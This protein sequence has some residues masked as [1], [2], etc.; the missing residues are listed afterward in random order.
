M[1]ACLS[2]RFPIEFTSTNYITQAK[3]RKQVEGHLRV[4]LKIDGAFQT[5]T[6]TSSSEPL[7]SE[8]AYVVMQRQSFN[9]PNALKSVMEGFSISKGDRGEFLVLLLLVLARDATIGVP[10][11][12]GRPITGRR[13]FG[14]SDFLYGQL[15]RQQT[16]SLRTVDKHSIQALNMLEKDFPEARLHFNHYIKVHEQK[17]IDIVSLL[18][19]QGR[20]AAVLCADNQTGLD[21]VHVFLKEGTQLIWDNAGLVLSQI[22]NDP[23]YTN[24]PQTKLF[25]AMDPYDL[26]ILGKRDAPVPLIKIIFAL[27]AK[28]PCL[29]VI[30]HLPTSE[31]DAIVYEIWCAGISPLIFGPIEEHEVGTW[32]S[33]LQASYGWKELFK[34]TSAVTADLRRSAMPGAAHDSGHHSHWVDM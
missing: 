7:L 20:G 13:W 1:L 6:T 21:A 5:M 33:L 32:Y 27:A 29:N 17:A 2:Q 10:D 19:L 8:A 24:T 25:D 15:F 34:G 3:E 26:G 23:K 11:Q 4:C 12:F 9:V 14:L 30:C 22:K 18:L 28:T 31:Y 16:T